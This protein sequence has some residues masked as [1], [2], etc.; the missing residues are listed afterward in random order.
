MSQHYISYQSAQAGRL[1][2]RCQ[3]SPPRSARVY[4]AIQLTEVAVTESNGCL[5]PSKIRQAS[6]QRRQESTC[7]LKYRSF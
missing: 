6:I 7:V 4:H 5:F 2:R 3:A 1:S